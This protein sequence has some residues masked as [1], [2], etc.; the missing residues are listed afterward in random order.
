MQSEEAESGGVQSCPGIRAGASIFGAK[1][2]VW[3]GANGAG[4]VTE[5]DGNTDKNLVPGKVK[6][7]T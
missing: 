7:V 5:I 3:T 6:G 4:E 2:P 1:V